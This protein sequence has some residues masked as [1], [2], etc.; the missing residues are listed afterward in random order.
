[1]LKSKNILIVSPES[2]GQL[3]VSKHHYA[4]SLA[5]RNNCVFFL[6]PPSEKY[7]VKRSE[8]ENLWIVDYPGFPK[9]MRF[10][11]AFLQR[12][13]I[14]Q[15]FKKLEK[16][17]GIC[18]DIIWSFDNS[19]FFDFSALSKK[20]IKIS[21]IVDLNQDFQVA[22]SASSA[23]VCFGTNKYICERFLLHNRNTFKIPHGVN[24]KDQIVS[25]RVV[26]PGTN[27]FKALYMGN[28]SMIYIDWDILHALILSFPNVDFLFV[29]PLT[30]SNL[31]NNSNASSI[32]SQIQKYSNVHFLGAVASAKTINY[33]NAADI[34][35][36]SYRYLEFPKQLASSHKILEYLATGKPILATWTEEFE[37]QELLYMAK[38]KDEFI[39]LFEWVM[40]N[41][42]DLSND[43]NT[44]ARK[45]FASENT[46]EKLLDRIEEILMRVVK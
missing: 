10:A 13:F 5:L 12:F 42:D 38:S 2:W 18:F 37:D 15:T 25:D 39:H 44:L 22:R 33:L 11:P 29:G 27:N 23:D 24:L 14:A 19:V 35:L 41:I 43:V 4:K 28:L 31:S 26:L 45:K 21:H 6:N 1:M 16:L 8:I 9:G 36:V 40:L 3:F 17:T 20:V 7:S 30:K 34:L 32:P 46:Y